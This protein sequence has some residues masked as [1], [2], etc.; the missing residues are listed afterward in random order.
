ML[1]YISF[2]AEKKPRWTFLERTTN[3]RQWDSNCHLSVLGFHHFQRRSPTTGSGHSG[4]LGVPATLRVEFP[5]TGDDTGGFQ[6]WAAALRGGLEHRQEV[7]ES[8]HLLDAKVPHRRRGSAAD[9]LAQE[10]SAPR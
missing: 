6:W 8:G 2:W 5:L 3:Q 7:A 9:P 10:V 1:I 4:L